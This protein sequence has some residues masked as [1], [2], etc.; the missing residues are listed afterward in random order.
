MSAVTTDAVQLLAN[1][2]SYSGWFGVTFSRGLDRMCGDGNI[3]VTE[4]WAGTTNVW[5]LTPWTPVVLMDGSDRIATGYIDGYEPSGDARSHTVT[6][7]MRSKTEDLVDCMLDIQSGQFRGYTLGA[8]ANAMCQPFGIGVVLQTDASMVVQDATIQRAETVYQFLERLARM[9][10]VL[11][12]DDAMGNLV[13]TRTGS[14][15]ASGGLVYGQNVETYRARLSVAKRFSHYIVKGQSGIG[16]TGSVQTSQRAVA[17]DP[18]VPR[19]R[20]HVSIAE[21]QL[22]AEGMQQ[23]ANWEMRYA[24]G[25]ATLADIEVDGWRQPDGTLWVVNQMVAVDCPPLQINADML[26]AGVSYKYD[27][28]R[29]KTCVLTVGPPEGFTPDPGEVRLRKHRARGRKGHSGVWEL[30]GIGSANP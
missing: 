22:S 2:Q 12:T 4:R 23:R 11:L 21:S 5:Q 7:R 10:A 8:I 27:G 3:P 29:G 16:A 20:P 28:A 24:F 6:I 13:L 25:R 30:D 15:A 1:G 26:I 17:I 18:G 19:Y 14:T 9:S